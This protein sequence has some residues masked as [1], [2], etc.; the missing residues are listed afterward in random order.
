VRRR[1]GLQSRMPAAGSVRPLL[2]RTCVARRRARRSD[3]LVVI[4]SN[5]FSFFL[6]L[7]RRE[8]AK[9]PSSQAE[10]HRKIDWK[11]N[12]RVSFPGLLWRPARKSLLP[13]QVRR[14]ISRCTESTRTR[15][16]ENERSIR[17]RLNAPGEIAREGQSRVKGRS[18]ARG[19]VH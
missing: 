13:I 15:A 2:I 8:P 5:S 6:K 18:R 10:I 11:S 4:F 1:R 7:F 16:V 14:A 17:H 3:D 9:R 12:E 19:R